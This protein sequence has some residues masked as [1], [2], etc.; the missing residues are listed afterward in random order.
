MQKLGLLF[1]SLIQLECSGQTMEKFNGVSFVASRDKVAQEHVD[2]VRN[3]NAKCAAVM[4]FGFIR[5]MD[6]PEIIFD[7]SRQWFGETRTGARQYID[8]LHQN[9]LKVMLKPQIWISRGAFTGA[10]KMKSEENWKA[11]EASYDKFILAYATLAQETNADAFCIGTELEQF[12]S[13][14]PEYW[15]QLIQKIRG[16]YKGKLTYAANWDE[17]GRTPFWEDLD[18]I[19]IDAYFPLSD[20]KTPTVEQLRKGW[21]PHKEKIKALSKAKNKPIIFTEYGYRSNDYTAKKP[22]L[23]DHSQDDVNLEAQTNATK[24]IFEEFWKEEWFAGGFVWKWFIDHEK[25]GGK[26]DN[27]FTPQNKPA[28]EVIK[29]Y[30]NIY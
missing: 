12:V 28:Q 24:A 1:L 27:R 11:L 2:A 6:S 4:P 8:I 17:Y 14:R 9:G 13:H 10:L 20:E 3:V 15:T 30:Y 21:Q 22:W 7:T 5:D 18:F 19:G 25:A 29:N 23:V 26:N 16:V